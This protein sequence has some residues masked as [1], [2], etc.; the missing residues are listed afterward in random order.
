MNRNVLDEALDVLLETDAYKLGHR[1]MYS[2]GTEVVFSN[3]TARGTRNPDITEGTVFFGLQAF[4]Y[5]LNEKWQVFFDL[6]TSDLE[7]VLDGYAAFVGDLLGPN[8]VGVEQFRELHS[9]GHLP[10]RVRA[11]REGSIV[12]LRVPYFTI[13]NTDPRF[14]W[15]TNYLETTISAGLW[16]PITS[17]TIAWSNR[18]LLDVRAIESSTID[19]VDFQGHDFS[20]RGLENDYA[21][22]A[23]G[24]GHLVSFKGTDTLP[25]IRF[26]N[27]YYEGD[28]GLVGASVPAT[29]HAV[30]CSGIAVKGKGDNAAGELAVFERLL[31]QHP[32][33]IL[34]VVSDSF[35]LWDVCT[36]ILPK[37]KDKITARDGK[38]VIRPDCYDN[39]TSILTPR[40]WVMFKDLKS[41]DEVAQVHADGTYTFT[42]PLKQT[43]MAYNGYMVRFSDHHGKC[44][45]L[46]TP[47]H[48]MLWKRRSGDRVVEAGASNVGS[49]ESSMYRS[50]AAV[51]RGMKLSALDRFR[52]AF[53]ADGSYPSKTVKAPV[54]RKRTYR[55]SFTKKRKLDRLAG[56]CEDGGFEYSVHRENARRGQST[57]Y[58]KLPDD[59]VISKTFDW[60]KTDTLCGNWCREFIE[61]LSYWDATRRSTERFKFDTT[62]PEVADV[63]ELVALS[64]GYGVT[65]SVYAD[66]REEHFS[67]TNCMHIMKNN[68]LGGQAITKEY[69]WYEGDIHCVTVPTG[70]LLVKR[71]RG[72][73]VCGNSG[74][75][76]LI[77]CGNPDA[78][79]GTPERA[80]VVNLLA[81]VFGTTV[82]D[83]GYKELDSH[84]G[85]IYGDSINHER[86][87]AITANLMRQGYASTVPAFGFGS[88]SYQFQTRD[89]F[90]M[91]VKAT[92][93]QV[94]GQGYD[95]LKDPITDDGGKK[96]ATGRL[97]VRRMMDG[98]AYLIEHATPEQ[99]ADQVLELVYENGKVLRHQ[100][101]ADVR[102]TLAND[103][104]V[105]GRRSK[106]TLR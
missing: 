8:T 31:D 85:V 23:S 58:V 101:F 69:Q 15:L 99:E 68:L 51:D 40:G 103:S 10:L 5:R 41:T 61:E 78:A 49:A 106:V 67:N 98:R 45:L 105:L 60:V 14:F 50:A 54:S 4:L 88:F 25:A 24:A 74:D 7:E 48:R 96:S 63:A 42:R 47:N 84:I 32:A 21:A 27:R 3:M 97:A 80:G 30:M 12:P 71:G 75:P 38:L 19:A 26:V 87:D 29:E 43:R 82:N 81:E 65:R 22:A 64:A 70:M 86:A 59:V 17:A 89:T 77:L 102:A 62:V 72:I 56:I 94:N 37:L 52:I 95:I 33:G 79:E 9:V 100:S 39:D 73:A 91:V 53:Q 93:T 36:Q 11:F 2:E 16:H 57:M 20:Y 18:R 13:E 44:D 6:S 55:F 1:Y 76:E 92:W 66:S 28:N 90:K 104:A 83:K 34:S 46:V 35:N